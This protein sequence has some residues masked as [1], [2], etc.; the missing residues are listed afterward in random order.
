MAA[1]C[2]GA[3]P[4]PNQ[5]GRPPASGPGPKTDDSFGVRPGPGELPQASANPGALK[6]GPYGGRESGRRI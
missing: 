1:G 5:S 3:Y 2:K 6:G 4:E